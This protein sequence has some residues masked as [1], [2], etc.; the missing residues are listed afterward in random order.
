MKKVDDRHRNL[1]VLYT[2]YLDKRNPITGAYKKR[3]VVLTHEAIHWFQRAE[4]YDLFGEERGHVSLGK[5]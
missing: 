5:M 3:F 4:G 2:A 1:G